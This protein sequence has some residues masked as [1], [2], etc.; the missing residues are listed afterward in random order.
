[1]L[2][3][4]ERG[5]ILI[6]PTGKDRAPFERLSRRRT[7]LDQELDKGAHLLGLLPGQAAL[8]AVKLNDDIADAPALTRLHHQ[9]LSQIV[10]FVEQAER[11]HAVLVGRA[12]TLPELN[13]V[14]A[15]SSL[16]ARPRVGLLRWG[17]AAATTSG[18]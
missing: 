11:C 4:V 14:G 16:G 7:L 6:Q 2:D 13:S 8:A 17:I 9:V 15:G 3:D 18:Q 10:T 12:S 5:R 1:V